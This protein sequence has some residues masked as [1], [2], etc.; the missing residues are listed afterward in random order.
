MDWIETAEDNAVYEVI[1]QGERRRLKEAI[2][3]V[4]QKA[5]AMERFGAIKLNKILWRA[6]FRSYFMREIPVTGRQYQRL[7][8]GPAPVEMPIVVRDLLSQGL[9][10]IDRIPLGDRF[11]HRHIALA[12]PVLQFFSPHDL[13]YLDEAI[14]HYHS[15]TGMESSDES[16]G[17]AWSTREDGDP[18][19]YQ[20]ALFDDEPAPAALLARMAV[21]AQ[22]RRWRS[23]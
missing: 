22:E 15:M 20:L 23:E 11:E 19:P 12:D 13:E 4:C 9:M 18:M 14:A 10:R 3:Y 16:H 5:E 7:K 17:I 1:L 6:D 21:I 8:L 2:L